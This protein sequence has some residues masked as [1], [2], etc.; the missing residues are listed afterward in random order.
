MAPTEEKD[1]NTLP[2]ALVLEKWMMGT[3]K[4]ADR[5]ASFLRRLLRINPAYAQYLTKDEDLTGI[6]Q[7]F[8]K[9]FRHIILGAESPL[10]LE[11]LHK[12]LCELAW[13]VAGLVLNA[14]IDLVD[15]PQANPPVPFEAQGQVKMLLQTNLELSNKLNESRRAYLRELSGHRDKQR[16]L[17]EKTLKVIS[18][19][20]EDPIMFYEPLE[21]VLDETTK[22]FVRDV[23]EERVKLEMRCGFSEEEA[24]E[25]VKLH[26][27]DLETQ[28]KKM[29]VE[30]RKLNAA[31]LKAEDRAKRADAEA[32]RNE[33]SLTKCQSTL[34]EKDTE[35]EELKA[36]MQ[37]LEDDVKQKARRIAFFEQ[38]EGKAGET[39]SAELLTESNSRL[40]EALEQLKAME[41]KEAELAKVAEAQ[42]T[43]LDKQLAA[44]TEQLNAQIAKA[45]NLEAQ[46]VDLQEVDTSRKVQE[47]VGASELATQV[48]QVEAKRQD[49]EKLLASQTE[50]LEALKLQ[51]AE[52]SNAIEAYKSRED[53]LETKVAQLEEKSPANKAGKD[54]KVIKE[55][56][57]RHVEM[58]VEK[59]NKK[60]EEKH[61]KLNKEM[62]GTIDKLRAELEDANQAV[63]E[64]SGEH[65][66]K[67]GKNKK[68]KEENSAAE[69][70]FVELKQKYDVLMDQHDDLQLEYEKLEQKI[71]M[72]VEKL[73]ETG[74]Q[75]VVADTLARIRLSAPAPKKKKRVKAYQRLYDDAQRRIIDMKLKAERAERAQEKVLADAAAK[76]RDKKAM[77]EVKMLANLQ[78]A[79][80]D[81]TSRF[82]EAVQKFQTEHEDDDV[83]EH[84]GENPE[85]YQ[86]HGSIDTS[87][88]MQVEGLGA[89]SMIPEDS[90][91]AMGASPS[92]GALSQVDRYDG[93]GNSE[94]RSGPQRR[95]RLSEISSDVDTSMSL[96]GGSFR[97]H[98]GSGIQ[99]PVYL[100]GQACSCGN[101]FTEDSVFCRI[102]GK[103]RTE[104]SPSVSSGTSFNISPMTRLSQGYGSVSFGFRNPVESQ[105]LSPQKRASL[106]RQSIGD[107]D[108]GRADLIGQSMHRKSIPSLGHPPWREAGGGVAS[109]PDVQTSLRARQSHLHDHSVENPGLPHFHPSP[110]EL[111]STR[112][113]FVRIAAE[114]VLGAQLPRNSLD[115]TP[116]TNA[117]YSRDASPF[118]TRGL[119][120]AHRESNAHVTPGLNSLSHQTRNPL[121]ARSIG[122]NVDNQTVTWNSSVHELSLAGAKRSTKSTPDLTVTATHSTRGKSFTLRQ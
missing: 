70:D 79:A 42:R 97:G 1:N 96:T 94:A 41:A 116:A 108:L 92:D 112:Q 90:S 15:Q 76:A 78:K 115:T 84:A 47:Q 104:A 14:I 88:A 12:P 5:S 105:S 58:Q 53:D 111:S 29:T 67:K 35:L 59:A 9:R 10:K 3:A 81:T 103:K 61:A 2:E 21:F 28:V 52:Q 107:L 39:V 26:M 24:H 43:E 4:D 60:L 77:T 82:N 25:E 54:G 68:K 118:N 33:E 19:L 55:F 69:H 34:A 119:S 74:G 7:L 65:D 49:L 102:C 101:M 46:L 57:Q 99:A 38:Q 85:L 109:G 40:N 51:L 13:R 80:S 20:S 73:K 121:A 36:R 98:R 50:T 83:P 110:S 100:S 45:T 122:M 95:H 93:R 75:E 64:A 11:T 27:Q 48:S 56:D 114:S 117:A 66:E 71:A 31:A 87:G 17:S 91:P 44:Q 8:A 6:V 113:R 18:S 62:Q 22:E 63:A 32:K 23:V 120:G 37:P 89:N 30:N 106:Q 86:Q 72:L 16:K